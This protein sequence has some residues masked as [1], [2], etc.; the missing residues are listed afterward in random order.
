[1]NSPLTKRDIDS[2]VDQLL[3]LLDQI[4]C[5]DIRATPGMR[6]RIE[7]A[8]IGLDIALADPWKTLWI[9]F[10]N[11]TNGPNTLKDGPRR[12]RRGRIGAASAT[13]PPA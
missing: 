5:G 1:M 3:A 2:L 8:F 10:E 4:D 11:F 9:V 6:H 7:G 13:I 12:T